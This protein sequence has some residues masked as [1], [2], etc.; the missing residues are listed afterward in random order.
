MSFRDKTLF[1]LLRQFFLLAVLAM[2]WSPHFL[3]FRIDRSAV[4]AEAVRTSTQTPTAAVLEEIAGMSFAVSLGIHGSQTVQAAE[5]VLAGSL[6]AGKFLNDPVSLQGYPRDLQVGPPTFRLVMASLAVE[7]LLLTAFERTRDDRFLRLAIDR[8]LDF[9]AYES[10]QYQDEGFLWNDHAVAAR[11]AVLARLWRQVRERS[12]F[13]IDVHREILSLVERSGRFLSKPSHFTVRTNHGVMQNLALLQIG[14]AFP[15]LPEAAA[16]GRLALER[17]RIQLSFYIS[18]EGFVLEHSAE[19]HALGTALLEM[20]NRLIALNGLAPE[21]ELI[22]ATGKAREVLNLLVRPDGSLPLFGD[23]NA[24]ISHS[25]PSGADDGSMP[26]RHLTPPHSIPKS[27]TSLFPLS[28]YAIWWFNEAQGSPAQTIIAWANHDS[29]AHKH[30]DEA[31]VLFWSGGVD[32]VT[33]TGYWP[34]GDR[35]FKAANSWNGSNAPHQPD[36]PAKT[37]RFAQLVK[38]GEGSG[39]RFLDVER[40]N[41]DGALFRRQIA[42]MSQDTLIVVDF[43]NNV[44]NGAETLWTVSPLLRLSQNATRNDFVSSPAADGRRLAISYASQAAANLEIRRASEN[45]FAGW[46]VVNG[47]PMPADA[48]R[49]LNSAPNSASATLFRVVSA[50]G[51]AE[52]QVSIEENATPDNWTVSLDAAGTT[53]KFTRSASTITLSFDNKSGNKGLDSIVPLMTPPDLETEIAALRNAYKKAIE[54][55]PPWRDLSA[56]R[57]KITY[58]LAFL[59]FLAEAGWLAYAK[60]R[61]GTTRKCHLIAHLAYAVCYVVI[62]ISITGYLQ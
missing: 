18:R 10:G 59:A 55:Y 16:W 27:G 4:S 28:G 17:L 9:S 54:S 44:P 26:I 29:Q 24:G 22:N 32:W 13:T 48:L 30:A 49:I 3:H 11:I 53:T 56:Y 62:A 38:T 39:I 19:Y 2:A 43:A 15:G 50:S 20:A 46:V 12:E 42:Q 58:L 36:E 14:A 5:R 47:R 34:Y 35:N 37:Q 33:G 21:P 41:A 61:R 31:S 25:I 6:Q 60:L 1:F 51:Q 7:N 52:Q 23:T 45:P 8:V 40:R 57:V